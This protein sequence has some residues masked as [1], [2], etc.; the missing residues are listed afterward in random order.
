[1]RK[2]KKKII[3]KIKPHAFLVQKKKKPY[4]RVNR[5][6]CNRSKMAAANR[7]VYPF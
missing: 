6:E 3:I 5:N 7:P 2:K 1:M 4:M